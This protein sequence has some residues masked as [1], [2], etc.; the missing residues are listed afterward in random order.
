M[1]KKKIELSI[2]NFANKVWEFCSIGAVIILGNGEDLMELDMS[3]FNQETYFI[4]DMNIERGKC[5]LIE[6]GEFKKE[7]YKFCVEH[8]D[9]VFRGT[10]K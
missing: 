8:E 7:L 10:G 3:Q 4:S 5:Y 6:D 2:T 9:R 1:N